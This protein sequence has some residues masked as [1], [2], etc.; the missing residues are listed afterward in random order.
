MDINEGYY[1]QALYGNDVRDPRIKS[2][3]KEMERLREALK[4]FAIYADYLDE[5]YG[6]HPDHYVSKGFRGEI[7]TFGDFRKA[8]SALQQKESE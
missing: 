8:R 4:I 5:N 3:E 7:I 2:L 6:D 1:R